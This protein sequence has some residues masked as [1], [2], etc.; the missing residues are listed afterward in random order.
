MVKLGLTIAGG[1]GHTG[2]KIDGHS[3]SIWCRSSTYAQCFVQVS[4]FQLESIVQVACDKNDRVDGEPDQ[5][6]PELCFALVMHIE[7]RFWPP[8]FLTNSDCL[9][10]F[11]C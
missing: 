2:L 7:D 6:T 5:K 1:V 8:S 4:V 10:N 3:G 11:N 9:L